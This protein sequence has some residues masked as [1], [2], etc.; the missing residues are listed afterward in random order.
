MKSYKNYKKPKKAGNNTLQPTRNI[1]PK[2]MA[3]I[4]ADVL[5]W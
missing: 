5:T 3:R 2:S 4:R 1:V